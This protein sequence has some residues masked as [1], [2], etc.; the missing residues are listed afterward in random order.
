MFHWNNSQP[1]PLP[2]STLAIAWEGRVSLSSRRRTLSQCSQQQLQDLLQRRTSN[3]TIAT[4]TSSSASKNSITA[5]NSLASFPPPS[6]A[7][8]APSPPLHPASV[9]DAKRATSPLERVP[10]DSPAQ[11]VLQ[12]SSSMAELTEPTQSLGGKPEGDKKPKSLAEGVSAFEDG[13]TPPTIGTN[14]N[15]SATTVVGPGSVVLKSPNSSVGSQLQELSTADN[16]SL[17][18]EIARLKKLVDRTVRRAEDAEIRVRIIEG[19]RQNLEKNLRREQRRSED[20]SS[21][22]ARPLH[23]AGFGAYQAVMVNV[24][25]GF[26]QYRIAIELFHFPEFTPITHTSLAPNHI[27]TH[28]KL[29]FSKTPDTSEQHTTARN[30]ITKKESPAITLTPV[31][32]STRTGSWA[33]DQSKIAAAKSYLPIRSSSPLPESPMSSPSPSFRRKGES[34]EPSSPLRSRSLSN[35]AAGTLTSSAKVEASPRSQ[36]PSSSPNP[37]RRVK[38]SDPSLQSSIPLR[39]RFV[40]QL[41]AHQEFPVEYDNDPNLFRADPAVLSSG[42]PEERSS[43]GDSVDLKNNRLGLLPELQKS[44]WALQSDRDAIQKT[45]RFPSSKFA[46]AFSF[47]TRVGIAADK[48]DHHPE[49]FN[50]YDRIDITLSTHDA[51]GLSSRDVKLA[52]LVDSFASDLSVPASDTTPA[53]ASAPKKLT[54]SELAHLF[55]DLAAKGWTHRKET[56]TQASA[57]SKTFTFDGFNAAFG[58]MTRVAFAAEADNHHPEWFNVYNRVEVTLSTHDAGGLSKKDVELAKLMD[59]IAKSK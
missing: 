31:Q 55:P 57:I 28:P 36:K 40:R 44:G 41:P 35:T 45:F 52:K 24:Q 34:S 10:S 37:L 7:F 9:T 15:S 5:A 26:C 42:I 56:S 12:L 3:S 13:S 29:Q 39:E 23:G 33:V 20:V 53:P 11:T 54:D 51:N 17:I 46:G 19:E 43:Q 50:V 4:A 16:A 32:L 48:M 30:F 49:W 58:F 27:T 18:L 6:T 22:I 21:R 38:S 1:F 59:S 25:Q 8:P 14:I 2:A 47:M